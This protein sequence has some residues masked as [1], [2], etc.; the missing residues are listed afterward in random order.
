VKTQVLRSPHGPFERILF[1]SELEKIVRG[2]SLFAEVSVYRLGHTLIDTA[3]SHVSAALVACLKDQPPQQIILTH[4]HEDH[5]GGVTALQ[6]AFGKIPVYAPRPH[7]S[8]IESTTQV[9]PHRELYWGHPTP[10]SGLIPYDPGASFDVRGL[11]LETHETPGH[12]PGHICLS[13][14]WGKQT[15]A[16]TGDIYFGSRFIPAFFESAADDLVSSQRKIAALGSQVYMLPTHGK[17]RING[18]M[19]LCDAADRISRSAEEVRETALRIG[20][21]DILEIRKAHFPGIDHMG[22]QTGGEI[23]EL[24][25]VRSVMEPVQSLPAPSLSTYFPEPRHLNQTTT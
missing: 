14:K 1:K 5:V 21:H 2:K 3:S 8:I 12:T 13:L 22:S 15:Y 6:E 16:C 23:S 25:F 18:S 24:A 19:V 20:S 4:Q 17:T 11:K 9:L 10:P 7:V